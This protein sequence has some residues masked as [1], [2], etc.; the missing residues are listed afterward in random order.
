MSSAVRTTAVK[1][2]VAELLYSSAVLQWLCVLKRRLVL[3]AAVALLHKRVLYRAAVHS[4][5][6]RLWELQQQQQIRYGYIC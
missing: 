2:C 5:I 1:R 6:M 3:R 4:S